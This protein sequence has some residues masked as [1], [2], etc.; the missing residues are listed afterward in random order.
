[1][2]NKLIFTTVLSV[3]F[4]M[5]PLSFT[6]HA[7]VVINGRLIR[8]QELYNLQKRL[9]YRIQ[10]GNYWFDRR[11]G[12]WG[13]AGNPRVRGNLYRPVQRRRSL[14]ERGLLYTPPVIGGNCVYIPGG[15]SWCK[16]Q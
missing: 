4:L 8:G 13:Y 3:C 6:A 11:T 5:G 15:T 7:Q 10:P 14:S 12:N 16:G 9:G 2:I 1:M